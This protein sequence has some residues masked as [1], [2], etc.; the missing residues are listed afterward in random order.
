MTILNTI[1]DTLSRPYG[2]AQL[3]T[4]VSTLLR[5]DEAELTFNQMR[6]TFPDLRPFNDEQLGGFIG[7]SRGLIEGSIRVS[8]KAFGSDDGLVPAR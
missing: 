8:G 2:T 3:L 6:K 1:V 5:A 4:A 7:I